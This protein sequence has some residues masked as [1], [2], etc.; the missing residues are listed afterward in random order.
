MSSTPGSPK[1]EEPENPPSG[2]RSEETLQLWT[3]SPNVKDEVF[4]N[5]IGGELE[6]EKV[7]RR[8]VL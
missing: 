8:V 5:V 6:I 2:T 7:W 3:Q 4:Q 1:T